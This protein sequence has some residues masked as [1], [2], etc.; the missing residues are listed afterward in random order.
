MLANIKPAVNA[1]TEP[2]DINLRNSSNLAFVDNVAAKNVQLT[3][4][5]ILEE[6]DVLAEM[7]KN[8]EIKI[9]GAMYNINTSAVTFYE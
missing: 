7:E 8:G 2:L 6:S 9:I 1:V 4:D 3:I 5:R